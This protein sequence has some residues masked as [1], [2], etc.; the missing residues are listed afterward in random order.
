M[1]ENL[2]NVAELFHHAIHRYIGQQQT[3]LIA[4]TGRGK[5]LV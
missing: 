5:V 1:H 4:N 2:V 3:T